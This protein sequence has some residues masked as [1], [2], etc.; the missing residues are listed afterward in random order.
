MNLSTTFKPISYSP[1]CRIVVID[2]QIYVVETYTTGCKIYECNICVI[3]ENNFVL[4]LFLVLITVAARSEAWT[5]FACSNTGINGSNPTQDMDVCVYSAFVLPCVHSSL[6]MGWF[7]VLGVLP[8]VL[9]LRNWSETKSFTDALYSKVGA[10]GKRETESVS[11]M[12]IISFWLFCWYL[13]WF[14]V[15]WLLFCSFY[16][17]F[18][19]VHV[20]YVKWAYSH[21]FVTFND[22]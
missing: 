2:G 4:L 1:K 6:V 7:S 20:F 12:C 13:S 14:L 10:T 15:C 5:V 8:T 3:T 18:V 11:S 21:V 17:W 22:F 9:G 16:F 19:S